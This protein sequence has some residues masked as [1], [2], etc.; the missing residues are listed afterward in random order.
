MENREKSVCDC[1]VRFGS[2][3]GKDEGPAASGGLTASN[4]PAETAELSYEE[5][6]SSLEAGSWPEGKDCCVR[7]G[8]RFTRPAAGAEE[9]RAHAADLAE[10]RRLAGAAAG[11]GGASAYLLEFSP[12]FAYSLETRRHLDRV[13]KDLSGLPLVVAFFNASW[14]SSRVIEGLKA[15]GVCLCLMDAPRQLFAP[16]SIDVVTAPLVYVKFYGRSGEVWESDVGEGGALS[17]LRDYNYD[18]TELMAWLPRLEVLA[19]QAETVRVIFAARRGEARARNARR[20][21]ELWRGRSGRSPEGEAARS[22]TPKE[23]S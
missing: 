15:R 22:G 3:G 9:A 10:C 12:S 21:A 17:S 14:Y 20:L 1:D 2:A 6:K 8:R 4:G 5:W 16:P 7:L 13:L 19:A 18:D 11:R 23:G